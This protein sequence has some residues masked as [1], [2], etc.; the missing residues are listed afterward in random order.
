MVRF[1][2]QSRRRTPKWTDSGPPGVRPRRRPAASWP[3][4]R[5][6]RQRRSSGRSFTV[7]EGRATYGPLPRDRWR[8]SPGSEGTPRQSASSQADC[9][10]MLI[11]SATTGCASPAAL[12]SR[13]RRSRWHWRIPGRM[14]PTDSHDPSRGRARSR[15]GRTAGHHSRMWSSTDSPAP[16]PG[17]AAFAPGSPDGCNTTGRRAR[18]RSGPSRRS[19]P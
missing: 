2:A 6:G 7:P 4:G 1:A 19:P 17:P 12:P 8:P 15:T 5:S 3:S 16:R 18:R 14:G 11:P 9:I 13:N 10:A